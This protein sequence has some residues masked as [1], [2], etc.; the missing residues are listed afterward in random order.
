MLRATDLSVE[1]GPR[2]LVA[3]ASFTVGSGD[4][5]GLVG[6]NGA[7]KTTLLGTLADAA[8]ARG[9]LRGAPDEGGQRNPAVTLAGTLAWLPQES[10]PTTASTGL[11]RLLSARGLDH[12]KQRLEQARRRIDASPDPRA[13]DRAIKRFSSLQERFEMDG[14][15]CAEIGRASCRERV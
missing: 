6:S 9:A 8:R 14:G 5:V 2:L 10:P 12:A 15:Y 13:R 11:Q 3:D 7:G 1:I 4:V